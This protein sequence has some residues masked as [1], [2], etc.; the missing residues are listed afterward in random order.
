MIALGVCLLAGS[1]LAVWAGFRLWKA[2]QLFNLQQ[3]K[4]WQAQDE[5]NSRMQSELWSLSRWRDAEQ[6]NKNFGKWGQL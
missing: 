4:H 5:L 6:I 2:Q 3:T 1:V